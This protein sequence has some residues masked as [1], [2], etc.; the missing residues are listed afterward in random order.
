VG[1]AGIIVLFL[2]PLNFFSDAPLTHALAVVILPVDFK[3]F[4]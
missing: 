3:H 2:F 4:D 1:T